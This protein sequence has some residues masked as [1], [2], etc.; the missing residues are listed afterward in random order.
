[1]AS[2]LPAA[3]RAR[4]SKVCEP[5]VRLVPY[6]C[7][8]EQLSQVP[9]SRRHSNVALPSPEEN[10]K[11]GWGSLVG[12]TGPRSR[13]VSGAVASTVK[14]TE[15]TSGSGVPW[16][17]VPCTVK[18]CGPSASEAVVCGEVQGA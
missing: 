4:T 13:L 18:V 2:A 15:A 3:S 11:L 10:W 17:S 6:W 5:S 14:L 12:D 1:M 16:L 7:G 9:P 8:E